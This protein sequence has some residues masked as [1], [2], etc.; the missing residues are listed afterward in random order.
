MGP[1]VAIIVGL[2][3]CVV[4]PIGLAWHGISSE[5]RLYRAIK[6]K[7]EYDYWLNADVE[8]EAGKMLNSSS[9]N[10]GSRDLV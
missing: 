7:K 8:V 1:T 6:K 4:M 9:F 5:N 2:L 10:S 3:F